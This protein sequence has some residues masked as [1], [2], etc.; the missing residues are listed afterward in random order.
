MRRCAGTRAQPGSKQRPS[1]HRSC[2]G[3]DP[4]TSPILRFP[5]VRSRLCVTVGRNLHTVDESRGRAPDQ[6]LRDHEVAPEA[7]TSGGPAPQ[8]RLTGRSGRRRGAPSGLARGRSDPACQLPAPQALVDA[9]MREAGVT[10]PTELGVAA[11]AM[12]A[13]PDPVAAF[14][15][16]SFGALGPDFDLD[17]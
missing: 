3:R 11:L 17:Y 14:F 7:N 12:I 10:S 1:L 2:G 4:V 6:A 9:A 13:Q 5:R 16:E 15:K 8:V